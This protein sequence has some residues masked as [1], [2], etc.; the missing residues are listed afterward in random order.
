MVNLTLRVLSRPEFSQLPRIFQTLGLEYDEKVL[1]SI[2]NEVLKAVVVQFNA[3]QLTE[4]PNLSD[5]VRQSLVHRAKDFNIVLDDVAITH[6]LYGA[7]FFKAV[8]QNFVLGLF[9]YWFCTGMSG[10]MFGDSLLFCLFS[11]VVGD[12][13]LGITVGMASLGLVF[14]AAVVCGWF[15]SRFCH[16]GLVLWELQSRVGNYSWTGFVA[17][18]LVSF[19]L[20]PQ[21]ECCY[22]QTW[23]QQEM[24]WPLMSTPKSQLLPLSQKVN[25]VEPVML[26]RKKVPRFVF[27]VF[28]ETQKAVL[29]K[30]QAMAYARALVAGFEMD[31]IDDL[32]SF[33][34]AFGASRLREA[35][36]NFIELCKKKNNDG[37]WM[38]E[39][40]A[41]QAYSHSEFPYL[42]SSGIILSGEDNDHS[43]GIMINVPSKKQDGSIDA[44]TSD[45]TI[46]H[47]S[48]DVNQ[49]NSMPKPAQVQSMDGKAQVPMSWPNNVPQYMHNFP[50]SVFQQMPPPYQGYIFPGLDQD[51]DDHRNRKSSSRK[52][53]RS[54][55]RKRSQTLEQDDYSEP[56]ESSS[57]V[58]QMNISAWEK[59]F[60]L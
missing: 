53:E 60:F 57:R 16:C 18:V 24:S 1:L 32:I 47:G 29:R 52:K 6:L 49:D 39:V 30:E 45:S 58:I 46:S 38:D 41:M 21:L 10:L 9:C 15:P 27:N 44:S 7:E 23:Y 25:P 59:T 5:R 35:C 22:S 26:Y 54:S 19:V 50:G 34:D 8:E 40:A 37:L 36:I 56:S 33:A 51:P 13:E 17:A 43:Q 11:L 31:Y 20:M 12:S 55:H 14:V 42:G 4:G 2:G 3:D 28:L 48:S